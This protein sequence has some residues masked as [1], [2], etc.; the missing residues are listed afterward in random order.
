MKTYDEFLD[1]AAEYHYNEWL[2]SHDIN[3][4]DIAWGSL[5]FEVINVAAAIYCESHYDINQAFKKRL[6]QLYG[7]PLLGKNG[8]MQSCGIV[9][10]W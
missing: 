10:L 5:G 4:G 8:S 3:G 7:N 6:T 2:K 1:W 9:K